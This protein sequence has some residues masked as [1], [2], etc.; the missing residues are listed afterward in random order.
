M[1][2]S[3]SFPPRLDDVDINGLSGVLSIC[4]VLLPSGQQPNIDQE[5]DGATKQ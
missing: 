4:I 5:K 3:V 2:I 1:E